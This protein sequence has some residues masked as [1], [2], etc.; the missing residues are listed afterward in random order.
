MLMRQS[1]VNT[2]G[3]LL[4]A[5]GSWTSGRRFKVKSTFEAFIYNNMIDSQHEIS[6]QLVTLTSVADV[7]LFSYS[8]FTR[9]NA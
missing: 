9:K 1:G 3:S 6:L 2:Q 8:V 5:L 4:W 7:I